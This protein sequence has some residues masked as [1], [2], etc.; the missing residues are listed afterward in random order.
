MMTD[1][2]NPPE[3]ASATFLGLLI[4][5]LSKVYRPAAMAQAI[6]PVGRTDHRFSW[7]VI[8]RQ[9]AGVDR[10]QKPIVC[11]TSAQQHQ[12]QRFLR[13]QPVLG[14]VENDRARR[15]HHAIAHFLAAP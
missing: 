15:L 14:L 9:R 1:V 2:S 7:S 13:V 12:Q 3:Y 6:K 8:R 4:T 10:R 5:C 11:P